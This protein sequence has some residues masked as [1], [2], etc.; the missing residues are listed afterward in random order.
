MAKYLDQTQSLQRRLSAMVSRL[1]AV[2]EG[3]VRTDWLH[4][5]LSDSVRLY[6]RSICELAREMSRAAAQEVLLP[7]NILDKPVTELHAARLQRHFSAQAR[8]RGISDDA[9]AEA[10]FASCETRI[11]L[12]ANLV[13]HLE[14][15]LDGSQTMLGVPIHRGPLWNK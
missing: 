3:C 1:D 5:H 6:L 12:V 15:C 2:A 7:S 4:E 10:T 9:V 11:R 13:A 14:S 8:E